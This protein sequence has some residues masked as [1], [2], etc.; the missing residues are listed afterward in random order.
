MTKSVP[1][2]VP[3]NNADLHLWFLYILQFIKNNKNLSSLI[4]KVL[5]QNR[6]QND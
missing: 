2:G 5:S 6:N 1:W 4:D 3:N